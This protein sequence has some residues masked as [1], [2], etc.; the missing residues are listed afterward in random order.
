MLGE[1]KRISDIGK[2]RNASN[3]GKTKRLMADG[4]QAV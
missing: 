4:L 2:G 3:L 1:N